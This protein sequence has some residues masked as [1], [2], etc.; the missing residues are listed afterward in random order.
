VLDGG[1]P[2]PAAALID[3]VAGISLRYRSRDGWRDIWDPVRPDLMPRAIEL[4]VRPMRG[5]QTRY[6]FLVGAGL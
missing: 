6:L 4:V 1:E 3:G 2:G 5:P